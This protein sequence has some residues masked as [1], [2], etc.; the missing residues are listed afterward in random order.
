[1]SK[2]FFGKMFMAI[3]KMGKISSD[4]LFMEDEKKTSRKTSKEDDDDEGENDNRALAANMNEE[5][6]SSDEEPEDTE[7]AKLMGKYNE[8]HDEQEPADEEHLPSD[9]E[10]KEENNTEAQENDERDEE[11]QAEESNL[12]NT[13]N[14]VRNYSYD[15][16]KYLWCQLTFAVSTFS[17]Y[18][19][20]LKTKCYLN[21]LF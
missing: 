10:E 8:T 4:M 18:Y 11:V 5:V 2:K 6:D 13:Y 15:N 16:D 3:K 9:D 21:V 12:V 7:D 17:L 20:V 19:N 14:Y 1:M